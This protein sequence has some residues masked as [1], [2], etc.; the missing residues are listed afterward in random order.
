MS[1]RIHIFFPNTSISTPLLNNIFC[2]IF[3]FCFA[4]DV[5]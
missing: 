3:C 5:S 1:R 2:A 4:F